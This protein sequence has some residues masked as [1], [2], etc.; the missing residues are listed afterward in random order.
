[1][2]NPPPEAL[3]LLPVLFR[4]TAVQH[5]FAS[6]KKSD[7]D[8]LAVVLPLLDGLLPVEEDR[9]FSLSKRALAPL[10]TALC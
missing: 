9:F 1:M 10:L 6:F 5:A 8:N 4:R 3:L 7:M 2:S